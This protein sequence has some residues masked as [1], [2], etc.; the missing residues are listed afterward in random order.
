MRILNYCAG[1]DTG[2]YSIRLKHAFDAHSHHEYAS[3]IGRP[4]SYIRY[5]ID[6][7]PRRLG[8]LTKWADVVHVSHQPT[9]LAGTKP[10]VVQYHG[11]KFRNNPDKFLALQEQA[12]A[13]AVCSTLD[14]YLEA[15]DMMEWLPTPYNLEWLATFRRHDHDTD[16]LR[17]GHSPTNRA[18]KSTAHLVAAVERLN[19]ET[20][21]R[22]ELTERQ[23]WEMCLKR[24]GTVDVYFDQ[25]LLGYGNNAVEAWGMGIPVIC[26]AAPET[27]AEMTRRFGRLPFYQATED[28]IYEALAAMVDPQVRGVWG[29]VGYDHAVEWHAGSQV[30]RIA[31]AVYDSLFTTATTKTG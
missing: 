23:S 2:G 3:V 5:P 9:P 1:Y 6:Q 29:Q 19:R 21:V 8:E 17:V 7:P 14:L 15:P 4:A 24:K 31:E 25:V 16:T 10:Q 30:V 22:L 18:V 13:V 11:T 20:P 27:L 28:T 12:G 26:G